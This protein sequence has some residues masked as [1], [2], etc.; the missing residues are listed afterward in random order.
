M[1]ITG[2]LLGLIDIAIVIA[3]LLLVGLIIEWILSALAGVVIPAQIRK[4][5]LVIVAL[6]AIYMIVALLLGSPAVHFPFRTDLTGRAF[7]AL[8]VPA[9]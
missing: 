6:I 2:L 3:I 8:P 7:A 9:A 5:F 4:I 1:S